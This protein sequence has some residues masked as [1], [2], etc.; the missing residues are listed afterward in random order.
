MSHADKTFFLEFYDKHKRLLY[1][2]AKRYTSNP[3]DADDLVQDALL[4]LIH[5]VSTLKELDEEKSAK[6]VA[7]TVKTAFLDYEKSKHTELMMYIDN[8]DFERIMEKQLPALDVEHKVSIGI[9]ISLLKETLPLRNW[10][11]LEGKY[12]TGLSDKEIGRLIGVSA[13]SVRMLLHRAREAA[14][15][16]LCEDMIIGMGGD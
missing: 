10:I 3:E 13:S 4:R 11:I 15:A 12:I 8:S 7:L 5:N 9:A 14:K 6:Y 2:L 16:V 1:Y